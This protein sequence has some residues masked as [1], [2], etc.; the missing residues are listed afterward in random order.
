MASGTR[1]IFL[2]IL[3][4]MCDVNVCT[5]LTSS[6]FDALRRTGALPVSRKATEENSHKLERLDCVIGHTYTSCVSE[7]L[8]C[9]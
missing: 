2:R 8:D 1:V 4:R 7:Q 6:F 3:I 9:I 5:T